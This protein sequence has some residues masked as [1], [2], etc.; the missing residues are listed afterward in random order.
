MKEIVHVIDCLELPQIENFIYFSF[1]NILQLLTWDFVASLQDEEGKGKKSIL[2]A[3]PEAHAIME[4]TG[5]TLHSQGL[6]EPEEEEEQWE[7]DRPLFWP[8]SGTLIS[9]SLPPFLLGLF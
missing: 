8:S 7:E 1:S 6:R 2:D 9:R 4:M 5:K 3:D